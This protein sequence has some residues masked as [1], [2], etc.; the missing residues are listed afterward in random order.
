MRSYRAFTL[1]ELLVV[2][3]II[4]LLIAILL[5]ALQATR[6]TARQLQ[7]STQT[8]GIHQGMVVFAQSNKGW[9][10][11][12]EG[13]RAREAGDNVFVDGS[14]LP[15]YIAGSAGG[16]HVGA[17]FDIMVDE[18]FFPPEYAVSPAEN[19]ETLR[20]GVTFFD[21][22]D[23]DNF[24]QD[25]VFYSYSLPEIRLTGTGGP[26][27]GRFNEYNVES[28]NSESVAISDRL[29]RLDPTVPVNPNFP[30][31]HRSLWSIDARGGNWS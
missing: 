23:L 1:I 13:S 11:G 9:Y 15:K 16:A 14:K 26:A 19:P 18:G 7:S 8:R 6:K 30:E 24:N 20:T 21:Y 10:P 12:V 5:P 17:R 22:A 27:G 31:T 4:A 28:F 25:Q 29:L 2:I 3:S